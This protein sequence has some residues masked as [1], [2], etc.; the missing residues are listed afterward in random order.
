MRYLLLLTRQYGDIVYLRLPFRPT[1][2]ANSPTG[3]QRVLQAN[4]RN[5][6]KQSPDF[7]LLRSNLGRGLL[8]S[9]GAPWLAE[10]RLLAPTLHRRQV[11]DLGAGMVAATAARLAGPWT[12]A[13]MTGQP[14]DVA[15]EMKHLNLQI[16]AEALFGQTLTAAES[17]RS[18]RRSLRPSGF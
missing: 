5:Y 14:L 1:I 8:T 4:N 16:V 12:T 10:R 2:L 18:L 9:E 13:V 7:A 17:R 6:T 11:A 15:A 3:V